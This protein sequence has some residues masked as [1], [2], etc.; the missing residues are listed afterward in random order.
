MDTIK[1]QITQDNIEKAGQII[2]D[3]G[4]VAFPTETV[5][6]LGADAT[7]AEA[8]QAIYDAKGR[9]SDNP[10]IV[11]IAEMGQLP[12][13][14]KDGHIPDRAERLMD[15]F[16]PGPITFVLP[17]SDKVPEI[18]TGG[19]DTVAVRMPSGEVARRLIKAAERPLA[20]PSANLSG[21]PS[22]TTA[23]DV[24]EDMDGR[25]DAVMMGDTCDVGIESTVVDL[26]RDVP[27]VLRPGYIT[28]EALSEKLGS[29]V[30]YDSSLYGSDAMEVDVDQPKSPGMKYRHYS[31][32][33]EV[34]VIQGDS[35]V[36][37]A[38]IIGMKA[39]AES[40]GKRV[41][42]IDYG[43]DNV[44]AAHDFFAELRE[45]DRKGT[46]LILVA[47]LSNE[48]LGFSVMNRIVRAAG[49]D[50]IKA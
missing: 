15:E 41:G 47:A 29:E 8:V 21:R 7:N 37:S 39:I 38:K 9:P 45:L 25:I 49:Y 5:Y 10:M 30:I 14:V 13:L 44:K 1:L 28:A 23:P 40:E 17:K 33:A 27:T 46:D 6:G 18:T 36:V 3:G 2:R 24:L 48:G 31:P 19:L 42:I 26:S 22:P 50:I 34:K 11:H 4:L 20:A 35:E 32:H 16:W 43:S 12:E